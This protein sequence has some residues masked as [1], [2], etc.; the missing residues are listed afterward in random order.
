MVELNQNKKPKLIFDCKHSKQL[1][2]SAPQN[3]CTKSIGKF[4]KGVAHASFLQCSAYIVLG[5]DDDL[6]KINL[7]ISWNHR[8]RRIMVKDGK[9]ASIMPPRIFPRKP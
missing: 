1:F 6:G 2:I 9:Y 5:Q 4:P 8:V 3:Y 7:K